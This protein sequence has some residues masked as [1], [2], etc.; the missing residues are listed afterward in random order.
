[1][2]SIFSTASLNQKYYCCQIW[3]GVP[4]FH[5]PVLKEFKCVYGALIVVVGNYFP[6]SSSFRK[7]KMSLASRCFIAI[8]MASD[9]VSFI[10][11]SHPPR[12]FFSVAT[13]CT[14]YTSVKP[15]RYV[16]SPIVSSTRIASSEELLLSRTGSQQDVFSITTIL[17][18]SNLHSPRNF[19]SC[20]F[21][22]S[23]NITQY[24]T[25]LRSSRGL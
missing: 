18:I 21:L 4:S 9:L 5:L 8:C 3:A 24:H 14:T 22:C 25:T 12:P 10:L 16:R 20:L 11:Q 17:T 13:R 2:D 7:D 6:P 1:M 15:P 23:N 19:T